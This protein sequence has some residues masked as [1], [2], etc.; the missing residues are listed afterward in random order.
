[1]AATAVACHLAT[2]TF[3]EPTASHKEVK[4]HPG[5]VQPVEGGE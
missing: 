3:Y 5:N 2:V 4:S 1:M